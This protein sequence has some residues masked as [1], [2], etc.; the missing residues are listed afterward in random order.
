MPVV[1]QRRPS[2]PTSGRRLPVQWDLRSF[3]TADSEKK[4]SDA[5]LLNAMFSHQ[6]HSGFSKMIGG[7]ASIVECDQMRM[8]FD[9]GK[10]TVR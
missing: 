2:A 6:S 3:T 10:V 5:G 9:A 7:L 4:Q 8:I 1:C